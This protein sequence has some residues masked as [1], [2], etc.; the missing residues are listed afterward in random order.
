MWKN[1]FSQIKNFFSNRYFPFPIFLSTIGLIAIGL[2]FIYSST[3]N[4][5][6]GFFS[7]QF[8]W[9]VIGLLILLGFQLID[10]RHI[11]SITPILYIASIVM[12][13]LVLMVG[14]TVSGS[15][16]WFFLG[17]FHIQPSE[18]AKIATVFM[19]AYYLSNIKPPYETFKHFTNIILI[20][21]VPM[22][23]ILKEPDLGTTILFYLMLLPML[24][25]KGVRAIS[26]LLIVLPVIN[27]ICAFHWWTWFAFIVIVLALLFINRFE[28]RISIGLFIF[29]MLIG[30]LTP[31]LWNHLHDYQKQRI[32]VFLDP[33]KYK[34]SAGY[35][36]IQSQV[37]IGS[38]G[39]TGKG[40]F[41]GTQKNL[42]FIPEKHTDF[43][44]SV[45][46][47]EAGL[48]GSLLVIFLFLSFFLYSVKV[49]SETKNQFNKLVIIGLTSIIM[50]QMFIN[51][52][53]T[54]S[55][56]P[57]TGI[58]LPF[59]SYGGSSLLI[60]MIISAI[61]MNLAIH[62]YDY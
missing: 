26:I 42:N 46:G 25:W 30:L 6:T 2:L 27:V 49:A 19:L 58:P 18:I 4:T 17:G 24:Y 7:K 36:I 41:M 39:I 38:G 5:E 20:V 57:V 60:N 32:M 8:F 23:L 12:L 22:L 51:I 44:F 10:Y 3:M 35:N 16:R 53:M 28:L 15:T 55:M 9:F 59:I 61:I 62:K 54:I 52:G 40:L 33:Y 50:F 37:S 11:Y 43:I 21:L 48:I 34:L 29:H 45:I 56:M 1:S 31:Y 47:E 14:K 13:V